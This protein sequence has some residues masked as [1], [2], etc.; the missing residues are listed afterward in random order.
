[1]SRGQLVAIAA[2]GAGIVL[3]VAAGAIFLVRSCSSQ[4]PAPE[5]RLPT[6]NATVADEGMRAPGTAELRKLGCEHALVVDMSR[7]LGNGGHVRPG[8]PRYMVTCDLPASADAPPCD[9]VA[10]VY[11]AAIGGMADDPIGVRVLRDGAPAPVCSH[12]YAPSGA[13]LGVFPPAQ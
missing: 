3:V 11:L 9:R 13:D 2:G 10:A 1:M 4:A 5:T 7:L 6:G 12:L 8:E